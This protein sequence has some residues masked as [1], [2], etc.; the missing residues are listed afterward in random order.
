MAAASPPQP[1]HDR[2]PSAD[3]PYGQ[4]PIEWEGGGEGSGGVARAGYRWR[5]ARALWR[6]GAGKCRGASRREGEPA[7]ASVGGA[8]GCCTLSCCVAGAAVRVQNKRGRYFPRHRRSDCAHPCAPGL[9]AG[10]H[11]RDSPGPDLFS[12]D[13]LFHLE[14]GQDALQAVASL[15]WTLP[16]LRTNTHTHARTHTHTNTRL[17]PRIRPS[18]GH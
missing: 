6:C 5:V 16:E 10:K 3:W 13:A 11:A 7:G 4:G 9:A 1:M 8:R 14:L 18:R 12:G 17:R 15:R 2:P